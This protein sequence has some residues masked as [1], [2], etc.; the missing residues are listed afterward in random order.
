MRFRKPSFIMDDSARNLREK[1]KLDR[2]YAINKIEELLEKDPQDNS[3]ILS[4]LKEAIL[5]FEDDTIGNVESYLSKFV[6]QNE[7][8]E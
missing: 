6:N 4:C 2:N 8:E 1:Q 5:S 7:P 3:S